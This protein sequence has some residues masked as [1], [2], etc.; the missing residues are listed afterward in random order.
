MAGFY[1]PLGSLS[2]I[3]KWVIVAMTL[4]PPSL[5]LDTDRSQ[6]VVVVCIVF[7]AISVITLLG[8]FASRRI[9]K[10]HYGWDDWLAAISLLAVLA[11]AILVA[12]SPFY[13]GAG[14]HLNELKME[15]L[16]AYLRVGAT[17]MYL[18]Y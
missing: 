3:R 8:R 9:Q 10:L 16:V 13:G 7:P 4:L 11:H 6:S 14:H 12:L 18:L 1:I 15:N 2:V 17:P 5:P